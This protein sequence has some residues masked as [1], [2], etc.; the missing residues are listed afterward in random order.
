MVC[1][2]E[3]RKHSPMMEQWHRCKSSAKEAVLLFRMGDFYE[4][5]YE[6]AH[7]LSKELDLTLTRRQGIPMS[8]VPWHTAESYIDRL[9][10][11]GYRVAIAEQREDS[12][13]TKGLLHR[14]IV[15]Y[16]TPG[17]LIS[18]TLLGEKAHNFVGAATQVGSLLGFAFCDITTATFRVLETEVERE[19]LNEIHRLNLSELVISKKFRE[20]QKRLLSECSNVPLYTI[21]EWRFEHQTAAHYLITHFHVPHLDGFGLKGRVAAINAAGALLAYMGEELSLN[22]SY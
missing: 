3:E 15:R 17:T 11:K 5:F 18:S 9:V 12:K 2:E 14:E 1:D 22:Q 4:A 6:D 8:G 19:L 13:Q 20:K 16:V 7:L 21:D 10:A